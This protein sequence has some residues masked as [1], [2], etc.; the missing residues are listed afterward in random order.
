MKSL[1]NRVLAA[2]GTLTLVTTMGVVVAPAAHAA[3]PAP[4]DPSN[5]TV[6]CDTITGSIKF[7]TPLTAAG[8]S[9]NTITVKG[10]ADGCTTPND[11]NNCG[12][13]TQACISLAPAKLAGTLNSTD[14]SC[15]GL[16]GLSTG[17]T[18]ST[19][20][21]F[22][23]NA[24]ASAL[25]G[26]YALPK[27][28]NGVTTTNISQTKGVT[29]TASWGATYG[30]FQIGA[31]YGT[32]VGTTTGAFTGGDAGALSTFDATTGQST[33]ALAVQCFGAGIK[34]ILFGIGH[35]TFA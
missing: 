3:G 1:R 16:S 20:T 24:K 19:T 31:T 9:P 35:L 33:A 5:W 2:A 25:A 13:G 10:V 34:S 28:T 23:N 22:K 27:L 32:T 18:G 6:A 26:G 11:P 17:T 8:G 12:T 4:V 15:T 14:N 7:A 30:E 29:Y 21:T